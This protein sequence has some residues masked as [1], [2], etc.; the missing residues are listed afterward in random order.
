MKAQVRFYEQPKID[1]HNKLVCPGLL[2][3]KSSN[4]QGWLMLFTVERNTDEHEYEGELQ[5]ITTP[6][7]K[8][9]V[10]GTKFLLVN[11]PKSCNSKTISKNEILAEG[12]LL[13]SKNKKKSRYYRGTFVSIKGGECKYRSGWE[14][15]Y[16]SYLDSNPDVVSWSYEKICI[17]YLSN[18][19]TGKIR[20]YYPDFLVIYKDKTELIEIKPSRK[21]KQRTVLKKIEAAKEWCSVRNIAYKILTEIELKSI[22]VI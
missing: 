20:K 11:D 9:F 16:M 15:K 7:E 10:K 3:N 21:L 4:R 13:G 5:W 2:L 19:K 18:K 12:K 6:N 1:Q 22:D 14:E 8:Y 17:E